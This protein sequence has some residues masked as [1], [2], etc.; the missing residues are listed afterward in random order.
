MER[1]LQQFLAVA[2]TGSISAASRLLNVTQPTITVN[3]RNLEEKHQVSLFE[4]TPRG[5]LLTPFGSIL[6]EKTQIMARLEAQASREIERR[7]TGA[8]PV[9]GIGCG[10]AWW[11]LFV[12]EAVEKMADQKANASF[13]VENGSNLHCMWKLLSGEVMVSIG[14]QIPNLAAGIGAEF[15]SLFRVKEGHFVAKGHPL[16]DRECTVD[17][18]TSLR[19]INN[20][21]ADRQYSEI[22]TISGDNKYEEISNL[23]GRPS[24]SSNSLLTC[25]DM[26][27]RTQGYIVFPLDMTNSLAEF[28]LYPLTLDDGSDMNVV[29]IYILSERQSDPE[30]VQLVDWIAQ[31]AEHYVSMKKV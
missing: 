3:I 25:V 31:A 29:G 23:S 7:R 10:H 20:V 21:P 2:D 11:N 14:H 19:W 12:R 5:M 15:I 30:M 9:I 17:D 13:S 16:L 18:L 8:N 6:F 4:R 27:K 24:Y 26:V 22:L 1:G 28:G